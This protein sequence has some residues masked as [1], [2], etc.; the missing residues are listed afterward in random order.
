MP[1]NEATPPRSNLTKAEQRAALAACYGVPEPPTED[2]AAAL[3][4][5]LADPQSF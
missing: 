5:R 3:R 4:E 2:E 1:L